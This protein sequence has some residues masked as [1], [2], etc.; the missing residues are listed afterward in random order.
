MHDSAKGGG[1]TEEG[2]G[3]GCYTLIPFISKCETSRDNR[4]Y[5]LT[6]TSGAQLAKK[7]DVGYASKSA[8]TN[9]PSVRPNDAPIAMEGTKIP[10]G[11]LQPY[12]MMT[13][14]RRKIVANVSDKTF[15][16]RRL[17]L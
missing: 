8:C 3:A 11:T 4:R 16:Q 10:A 5:R 13:K 17:W 14:N 9:I 12:E 7:L 1:G 2:I 15:C 6:G